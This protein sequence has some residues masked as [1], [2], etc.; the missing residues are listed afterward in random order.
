MPYLHL[1][2]ATV[3]LLAVLTTYFP[4]RRDPLTG[5]AFV[6][7]WLVGELALQYFLGY[8]VLVAFFEFVHAGRGLAGHVASVFDVLVLLGLA[9]LFVVAL[10]ARGVVRRALAATP[11]MEIDVDEVAGPACWG[12]WWK[13]LIAWPMP[14]RQLEVL[15]NV[16]YADD[17][18]HAHRLDVIRPRRGVSDAPVLVYIHGGAW[19]AGDKR[20]QG[21]PMMYELAARGWICVT[22]NYRLSPKA[23]WPAQI[24]DVLSSIAWV[25][26]HI[27]EFGGDPGFV[28]LAG[29]SAGGHLSALAA[30]AAG[31][32]LFQPG[33]EDKDTSVA[34]CVPIYGVH[35]MTASAE[36][37]GRHGP[38]LRILLERGVMKSPMGSDPEIYRAAS[39]LHRV[40]PGAPPFLVL[41]GTHDTLVPV[42]VARTFVHVFRGVATAPVAY[43]ELPLAQ[44][45][46]DVF[47]SPRCSATTQGIVAFLETV[48]LESQLADLWRRAVLEV[49]SEDGEVHPASIAKREGRAIHLVTAWNPGGEQRSAA[50]NEAANAELEAELERRGLRWLPATGRDESSSWAEPGFCVVGLDRVEAAEL[51]RR[52]GQLAIY[53]INGEETAAVFC[54][55]GRVV[56]LSAG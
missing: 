1:L 50:A 52:Y 46:F 42:V 24:V 34:A 26:E 2:V 7:G 6:T 31:D 9:G 36:V 37:G 30:L 40:H 16:A 4:V 17:G 44:H 22:V 12:A 49:Q 18:E 8:L 55:S 56:Q 33:F 19:V 32:P 3:M 51:G 25:K 48:R 15:K 47:A 20:E 11:G 21:R 54:D 53:E 10:R 13:S 23:T 28:A 41:Q 38:G 27:A 45:A 43:I 35:D 14:G 29:G 5:V 39:P